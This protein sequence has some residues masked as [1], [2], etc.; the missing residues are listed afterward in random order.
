M[1]LARL[2]LGGALLVAAGAA[3][4]ADPQFAH[5]YAIELTGNAAYYTM[6]VPQSVYAASA[7]GDLGDLRV[8]NGAG[9]P[10]AYTLD[11]AAQ[12]LNVSR[13]RRN[14]EW[15][16][17]PGANVDAS[18]GPLGVTIAADGSLHAR[19]QAQNA[20]AAQHGE[21]VDL[22]QDHANVDGLWIHLR[23]D[24][25]QGRVT[26]EQSDDLRAWEPLG[27]TELLRLSRDGKLLVQE[28]VDI[29][30]LRRRYL[31]LHWLDD[32]PEI[33]A[34]EIETSS[35]AAAN[36]DSDA[37]REQWRDMRVRAG[38][39]GG[40]YL[41]DTDGAY[42]VDALRFGLPQRN[43]LANATIYSRSGSQ[44][45]WLAVES[46]SLFR[47]E[48]KQGEKRNEPIKFAANTDRHWR[49]LVDT[50]SGG[51]GDGLPVIA[52]GWRAAQLTFLAR[53][54]PPFELAIGNRTLTPVAI[55]RDELL[56]G[57]TQEIAPAR[58]GEAQAVS[59]PEPG[60][61]DAD[62]DHDA[63]RRY[64]LWGALIAAVSVLALL[65]L[66]LARGSASGK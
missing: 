35:R 65:A 25:Y 22:G 66:K 54:N 17:L 27:D 34:I 5:R 53:G 20:G 12:P 41:F 56:P 36:P 9:E 11:S 48:D 31:R 29:E 10:V 59:A 19:A 50:R 3:P 43:T 42:P 28:R 58:L 21:L 51:I 62:Q 32:A 64:V 4:A 44:Q 60:L 39:T 40:E 13:A 37:T 33:G 47:L 6:T 57:G 7:R 23:N 38:Q 46:A 49:V 30:G 61:A 26:V 8:L 14:V 1:K 45:P 18:G 2:A 63:R 16:A 55:S 52:V 15:F 24:G